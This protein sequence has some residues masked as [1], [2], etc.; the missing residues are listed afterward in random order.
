MPTPDE[1][2]ATLSAST[3]KDRPLPVIGHKVRINFRT[4]RDG[5]TR[6]ELAYGRVVE[7]SQPGD[8][9]LVIKLNNT[10]SYLI[11]STSLLDDWSYVDS[12][13]EERLPRSLDEGEAARA[14]EHENRLAADPVYRHHWETIT[15]KMELNRIEAEREDATNPFGEDLS[16]TPEENIAPG[17][18]DPNA[19]S[20]AARMRRLEFLDDQI[21]T[22]ESEIKGLKEEY[23]QLS[24]TTMEH[25]T[26]EGVPSITVDGN[27][28]YMKSKTFV[29]MI[30]GATSEDVREALIASGYGAMVKPTYS[31]QSLG[32]LLR[33]FEESEGQIPIP[34]ALAAVVR[35][36]RTTTIGRTR[37]AA[38]KRRAP[39][40]PTS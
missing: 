3:W 11:N 21:K 7:V 6:W 39:I 9:E 1:L 12:S 24:A 4:K 26:Q 17:V 14:I 36:G 5:R 33:E 22:R 28:W 15:E 18:P 19:E 30:D 35:L 34:D 40:S 13:V 38:R 27:T 31:S 20:L 2:A 23:N 10:K 25:M 29:E 16:D 8:T 32:S 37:A